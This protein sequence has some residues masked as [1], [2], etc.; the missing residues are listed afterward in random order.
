MYFNGRPIAPEVVQLEW[1][2]ASE[3]DNDYFLIERST[4]LQTWEQACKV[5]GSGTTNELHEYS[6][7]DPNAGKAGGTVYY[8]PTQVDN[9]GAYTYLKII[10]IRLEPGAGVVDR[11]FPNPVAERLTVQTQA[12]AGGIVNIRIMSLEGKQILQ[13]SYKV[14][15]GSRTIDINLP[16]ERLAKGMYIL[17]VESGGE[18]YQQK[19]NKQ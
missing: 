7:Q 2:T 3:I 14:K 5:K 4:D 18:V 17:Q 16:E 6:C 19:I 11:V 15:P 1:G 9:N 8:R 13:A 12:A 10:K